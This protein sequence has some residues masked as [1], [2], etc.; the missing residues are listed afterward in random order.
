MEF[1]KLVKTEEL[2]IEG[3]EYLVRYFET[4]TIRGTRRY[5]FELMLGPTD[6]IILDGKSL[7]DLESKVTRLVPAT[8]SFIDLV[9]FSRIAFAEAS[10]RAAI[11]CGT[12]TS[13][14]ASPTMM[15][16]G[17]TG[18]PPIVIGTLISP[19]PFL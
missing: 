16:P 11:S 7:I 4:E 1:T 19:G 12:A 3:Q 5:S 15:S 2:K 13:P 17:L 6:R 9:S 18:M 14:S 10:T 8:I